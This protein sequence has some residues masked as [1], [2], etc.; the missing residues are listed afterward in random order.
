LLLSQNEI[1]LPAVPHAV[2]LVHPT[3]PPLPLPLPPPLPPPLD[4]PLDPPEELLLQVCCVPLHW[5]LQA[6]QL[7][8]C[9]ADWH[10]E[11]IFDEQDCSLQ[12]GLP[13][14]QRQLM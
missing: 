11:V 5:L 3:P 1:V 6:E 7:T 13:P 2:G 9:A 4:P 10:A 12:A 14:A 8:C